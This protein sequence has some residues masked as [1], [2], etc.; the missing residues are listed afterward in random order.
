MQPTS[1][2]N[3]P[4]KRGVTVAIRNHDITFSLHFVHGMIRVLRADSVYS[5]VSN[6]NQQI[7]FRQTSKLSFVETT[8]KKVGNTSF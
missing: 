6:T 3:N 4:K 5:V 7:Q 8:T 1:I 2:E